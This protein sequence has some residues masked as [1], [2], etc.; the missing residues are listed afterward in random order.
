[1]GPQR[2][3]HDRATEQQPDLAPRNRGVHRQNDRW[4]SFGRTHG[5][6]SPFKVSAS[7]YQ[8]HI[9]YF[10]WP[11]KSIS[12]NILLKIILIT[13]KQLATCC[14]SRQ[15]SYRARWSNH[16]PSNW[17]MRNTHKWLCKIQKSSR[18]IEKEK[19]QTDCHHV[20]ERGENLINCG[21][22]LR[23]SHRTLF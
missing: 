20:K 3:R 18:W 21:W 13:D 4:S 19:P 22:W 9:A 15:A 12:G 11:R 17:W 1:M 6:H 16:W 2:V 23:I 7:G 5:L 14:Y 10:H 8:E